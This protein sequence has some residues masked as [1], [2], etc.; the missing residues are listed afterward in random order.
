[1]KLQ[2]LKIPDW[3]VIMDWI[4]FPPNSYV[5]VLTPS[6]TIFGDKVFKEVIKVGCLGG[7]V[8]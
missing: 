1:M 4:V 5:E 3:I 6:V 7:S 8:G 2:H